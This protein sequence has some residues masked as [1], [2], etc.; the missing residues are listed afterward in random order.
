M[1]MD[2]N[3]SYTINPDELMAGVFSPDTCHL[4][5]DAHPRPNVEGSSSL[6]HVHLPT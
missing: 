6:Y 3:K 5:W 4:T 2:E 1:Q